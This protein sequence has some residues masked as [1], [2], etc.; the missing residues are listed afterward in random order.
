MLNRI[1][2]TLAI[3]VAKLINRY[4]ILTKGRRTY[5]AGKIAKKIY[6]NIFKE[7]ELPTNILGITGTNGK[8]SVTNLVVD[9]IEKQ[10]K[11]KVVNNR[12]G[13]NI[14]EG[15]ISTLTSHVNIFGKKRLKKDELDLAVL[16]IDERSTPILFSKIKP[17]ILII[18]NLIRDSLQRNADPEY[19]S[20]ILESSIPE[21]TRLV[22]YGN[23]TLL[24]KIGDRKTENEKVYVTTERQKEDSNEPFNK[25]MDVL[26]CPKCNSMLDYD[27]YIM[28]HIGKYSCPNSCIMTPE[29]K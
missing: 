25:V 7:L 24:K 26:I 4:S 18:N 21:T 1:R 22:M 13:S 11:K 28:N 3:I 8:T 27:Y 12:D 23:D 2:K 17:D 29:G 19:I 5:Q 16:E 15:I 14:E 10:T 9:L 6:P 20:Y